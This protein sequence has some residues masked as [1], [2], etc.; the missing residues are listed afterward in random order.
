VSEPLA[1]SESNLYLSPEILPSVGT[2]HR[3]S[4]A[5][6][7]DLPSDVWALGCLVARLATLKP[8]YYKERPALIAA[9]SLA[10]A[11]E[12]AA[13]ARECIATGMWRPAAQLEGEA[14]LPLGLLELVESCTSLEPAERPS[15]ALVHSALEQLR[16]EEEAEG[17]SD[18][19]ELPVPVHPLAQ[20]YVTAASGSSLP[21][22][23]LPEPPALPPPRPGFDFS[24]LG[25][26]FRD[27][28]ES[29]SR[30]IAGDNSNRGLISP[31]DSDRAQGA[32]RAAAGAG[33]SVMGQNVP[34]AS[35]IRI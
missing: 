35:R 19:L 20:A 7:L 11:D 3:W 21:D 22:V 2:V 32:A 29:V 15:S 14:F 6:A 25:A 28:T 18:G 30:R 27:L 1:G 4:A 26:S 16:E 10:T 17:A 34:E 33:A 8:L 9:L 12:R 23:S 13:A 31:S 5:R 24:L